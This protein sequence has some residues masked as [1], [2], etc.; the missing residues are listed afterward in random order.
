MYLFM[1]EA[2][3]GA[4]GEAGS[5]REARCRTRSQDPGITTQAKGRET[6]VQSHPDAPAQ[7][8]LMCNP[9]PVLLAEDPLWPEMIHVPKALPPWVDRDGG[10]DKKTVLDRV[11]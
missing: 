6:Q 2:E 4:E 1:R 10:R 8:I 11:S 5:P 7:G 3:T 9:D